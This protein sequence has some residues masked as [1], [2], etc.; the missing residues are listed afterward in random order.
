MNILTTGLPAVLAQEAQR[1]WQHILESAGETL[2]GRLTEVL[3]AGPEALQLP[4]VLACSPFV[5]DLLR[6]KPKLLLDL[7][8]SG[9][10]QRS[11]GDLEFSD[12]LHR[13]LSPDDAELLPLLRQY[14]ARHMLRIVWRDFSR[15]ADTL[16]TMRETSRL[17]EATITEAVTVAEAELE[18]LYGAPIGRHSG[19]VQ[20]LIVLAMGKLGAQE[21]NVS[22]D[23]DLIFVYPEGGNTSSVEHSISNEEFFTKVGRAV[24]S[25]LD[26]VTAEGFVFRV[27]MRLRPYGESGALVHN[28]AALEDYYQHQGRDWER[29][30]MIKARPVTGS[31]QRAADLMDLLRPFIY[32]RYV[33]FGAIESLR[34]MKQM[35][36]TEVRRRSLQDNVKLGHGGIREVEF[37]AQCF[38]LIRGGRDR[39]L[40]QR[41]LLPVLDECATLGCLP[42][43]VAA[44]LRTSYLFLRDSEHA[45]QGYQDKQ[46]QDLPQL[47]LP[48]A[49]LA[50]VMGYVSWAEYKTA[51]A[52]CRQVVAGH[53][54]ALIADPE[55]DADEEDGALSLWGAGPS[56]Q[57]LSDLGY[58][59]ESET[60]Q[61]LQVLQQSPRVATLQIQ[62]RNRLQQF[63]PQLL[64]ACAEMADPD[65][66][67]QRVLPLVNAVMRRS[68]Y[69]AMLLENP[70]ALVD[71]VT[72]CGASP[73]IAEQIAQTPVLLDELL[74]R[75]SLYT[76]PDKELLRDELRQQVAR[77]AVDDLEAQMNALR[78]FKASHVLRVA[79]S[80]LVGRLPL[81]QVSDKLTWI[82]EV[83]LEEV[84]AVAWAG[85]TQKYGQPCRDHAG[86]G[87]AV[88][89]YGKLGGVELGYGSDLDLVFIYDAAK[90]GATNG[91]NSIDNAVFYT[92][93][94]QRMIQI[95]ETQMTMGQLY[96]VDMRLRPSGDSGMLVSTVQSFSRYQQD[97]A[98]TWEHQALVRARFVAG[99]SKVASE[100]DTLR[101]AILS[102]PRDEAFLA[103]EVYAMREKMREHSLS[104]EH[105]KDGEFH[106]KQGVGGIVDIEFMVQYAVL[107]WAH[108]VPILTRWSD[109]VRILEALG[110]EG[111]FEQQECEALIQ[112]YLS[113]RSAAHQLALQ[114]QLGV[115]AADSFMQERTAVSSKWQKLFASYVNGVT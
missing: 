4:R 51:L 113:Y 107:A 63:M 57:T 31:A 88:F 26:Q 100:V 104:N 60:Y 28:F 71:L 61:A 15:L 115:S 84:L 18:S 55:L 105:L 98:W 103:R 95:I 12:E 83:I 52:L 30:A 2:A 22:S 9:Q 68:V 6:R 110:Q 27:D 19:E 38:Q 74:D 8:I 43:T 41:E 47:A 29:Y 73:W 37:I 66:A 1:V 50:E 36:S 109:N 5:A 10:L 59:Q 39:G 56:E 23:I 94:G 78:Y 112:A 82:A 111:L 65:L 91:E 14:R 11:L 58:R 3:A 72:L 62:G 81:M 70:P 16:E 44:E 13:L 53:F 97:S 77:L 75:A 48:R 106:L 108:R 92:R 20:Q 79:A 42:L 33:D 25:A 114:Q 54:A 86:L 35:I 64:R 45:I 96:E 93:L 24:I 89:G 34:G 99:D 46:S 21:L 76:A 69:L 102:E 85:L 87:F 80:E 40:Q 7:I 17:A 32:R 90:G 67:L 49:A 101:R